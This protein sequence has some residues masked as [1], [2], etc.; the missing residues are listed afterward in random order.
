[1]NRQTTLKQVHAPRRRTAVEKALA[2]T[3]T[4]LLFL[5][6]LRVECAEPAASNLPLLT[7]LSA[8]RALSPV[9]A[10][11]GYPVKLNATVLCYDYRVAPGAPFHVTF[12]Y[13]G[14]TSIYVDC[15]GPRLDLSAGD[16]VTVQGKSAPG[17]YAPVITSPSFSK[18]GR[19][20]LPPP[21]FPTAEDVA[22][23]RE[24]AQWVEVEGIVRIA[25]VLDRRLHLQLACGHDRFDVIVSGNCDRLPAAMQLADARVA[26]RGSVFA[27]YNN[28]RQLLGVGLYL[29]DVSGVRVITPPPAEPFA[30]A[31]VPYEELFQFPTATSQ[32]HRVKVRGVVTLYQPGGAVFLT[33]NGQGIMVR[34]LEN[35]SLTPGD[36][37]EALG[38][39]EPGFYRPLLEDAICRKLSA[40]SPPVPKLVNAADAFS[41]AHEAELVQMR[42]E[43]VGEMRGG[44]EDQLLL[45]EGGR[46]FTSRVPVSEP[47]LQTAFQEGSILLVT[48]ICLADGPLRHVAAEIWQPSSFQILAR[49]PSDIRLVQPAAWW[50]RAR[51]I[52][53]VAGIFLVLIMSLAWVKTL[54]R[55]VNQ[56]SVLIKRQ[57]EQ[58]A[59]LRERTRIA[60]DLH[61]TLAQ[62]FA[63]ITFALE[64][65]AARLENSQHPVRGQ[66]DTVLKL[67]RQSTSEAR[68]SLMNLRPEPLGQLSLGEA[69]ESAART[70]AGDGQVRI[71]AEIEKQANGWTPATENDLYRIGVEAIGNALRH[72]HATLLTIRLR[73]A[74]SA[75][76][77]SIVDNGCGFDLYTAAN[78]SGHFGLLGMR[79]RA[80]QTG[81]ELVITTNPGA[82]TAVTIRIPNH[83]PVSFPARKEENAVGTRDSAEPPL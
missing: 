59:A 7:S 80:R 31:S 42:A 30:A 16:F 2:W 11:K 13:D 49:S 73:D 63:G 79:E 12:I 51:L 22:S 81:G 15:A 24:D 58:E 74:D 50:T 70:M 68:R 67:V 32:G 78:K 19:S 29:C 55:R 17:K 82:G 34:T 39:P 21:K 66:I 8:V 77:L 38:F 43:L 83:P 28:Q 52:M 4:V 20:E 71:V 37:V 60:R 75:T 61:D 47:G 65:I 3:L 6:A 35:A 14:H 53:L 44:S 64:G 25:R 69:L 1:M 54:K 9:A 46:Y 10:A 45:R 40:A 72:A 27:I 33:E 48:G 23:G 57:L 76:V 18:V 62:G 5:F 36:E 26:M 41:G 56:Q